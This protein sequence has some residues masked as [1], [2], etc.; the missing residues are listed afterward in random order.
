VWRAERSPKLTERLPRPAESAHG[1]TDMPMARVQKETS[2]SRSVTMRVWRCC[3][4]RRRQSF[5]P[6][7]CVTR[8][9]VVEHGL[10][11]GACQA[12]L[13]CQYGEE[14]REGDLS[15]GYRGRLSQPNRLLAPKLLLKVCRQTGTCQPLEQ[16]RSPVHSAP[17]VTMRYRRCCVAVADCCRFEAPFRP[18]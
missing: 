10:G 8:V 12:P 14:S 17:V 13:G 2:A 5:S 3:P 11:A 7:D 18:R 16:S 9:A 15:V 4:T 1:R 6:T